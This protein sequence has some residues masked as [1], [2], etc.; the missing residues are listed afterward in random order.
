M[1][2]KDGGFTFVSPI[3]FCIEFGELLPEG[4]IKPGESLFNSAVF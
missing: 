1:M 4:A 3:L 2:C